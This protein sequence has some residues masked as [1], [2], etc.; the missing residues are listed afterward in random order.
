MNLRLLDRKYLGRQEEPDDFI[1]G[2]SGGSYVTDTRGRTYIDFMTGWCVGNLGWGNTEIRAAARKYEGPEYVY[3]G[4]LYRPWA[5]LAELLAR[6]TPGKLSVSYRTTGGTESVDGALQMAMA[7]TGRGKFVSIEDS[8]HGNSIATMS[9]G[10]SGNRKKFKNLL[11][12]CQKIKPPLDGKALGKVKTLLEK[13]D[14]AAF[15]MEPVICNL[16]AMVPDE[17]FVRGVRA[18]CTRYG[19]LFIAD[20]VATGF[21]RTGKLFACEH[22]GLEPDVLCMAKAITGGYGAMGAVITT[23]AIAKAIKED[24]GLYSTY[25]WHPRAVAVALANLRYLMRHR[26]Q[27]LRNTTQLGDY[28]LTRLPGMRF[29]GK[30]D[31]RGKGFAIGIEVDDERYASRVGDKCRKNGLLVSAEE[32][33]LMIFPA[34]NIA[35]ETAERGL[36]IFE[37]AL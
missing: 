11:P 33:V 32:N 7:Y 24:F 5:E 6:I 8:Y 27:L 20:E 37:Q 10:A 26:A 21:G 13:R 2:D 23:P 25:G 36:D 1:V 28:F 17:E 19:T 16:G 29:K 12:H 35:R 31:I 9:I 30:A 15:I 18:L 14:V 22:F 3:P 34:L 4:H